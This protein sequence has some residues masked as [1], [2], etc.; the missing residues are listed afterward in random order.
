MKL[1]ELVANFDRDE[2]AFARCEHATPAELRK[3]ADDWERMAPVIA[4]ELIQQRKSEGNELREEL[5]AAAAA[6]DE[7]RLREL[8][9]L[10]A[11]RL[12]GIVTQREIRTE[13]AAR[14]GRNESYTRPMRCALELMI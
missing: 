4:E 13:I 3:V 2:D 6:G 1:E 7:S 9:K 10:R 12:L 11:W 5:E 8:Y 14:L